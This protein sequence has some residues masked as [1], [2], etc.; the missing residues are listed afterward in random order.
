MTTILIYVICC[1]NNN[2][3]WS[4][5]QLFVNKHSHVQDFVFY[6]YLFVKIRTECPET[7]VVED[8]HLQIVLLV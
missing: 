6:L 8:L 3:F 2:N 4:W 5:N 7:N 1:S